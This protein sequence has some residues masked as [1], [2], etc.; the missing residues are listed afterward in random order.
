MK[1]KETAAAVVH[2]YGGDILGSQGMLLS[3]SFRQHGDVSVALHC[4]FAAV[5]CVRLARAL[6]LRVDTRALVR[7][8]LL[9]D[10]FL[11]D[12][13]DP[14]PSHRL[15]GFRHAGFAL[16]NAGRDFSLGPIERNMIA[17]HMLPMNLVLPRFRESLL[18]LCL[19][20]KI[21]SFCE[22]FHLAPPVGKDGLEQRSKFQ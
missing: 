18:L 15:H 19:A 11:Y 10:Y 4:F 22:T 21:C 3:Q 20:D 12:W 2:R 6:A 14:D 5:V 13:H 17:S 9:H 7:G 16:R 8:A 1:Y